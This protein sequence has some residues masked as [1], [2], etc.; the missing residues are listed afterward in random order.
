MTHQ[1]NKITIARNKTREI[2]IGSVTIGNGHPIAIQS[3]TNTDTRNVA[4]TVAQ[5]EAL[6]AEGCEIVRVA[7]PDKEA[8]EAIKEIKKKCS[9][10]PLI[11]DVHYDYRLGIM[12]VKNGADKLR[13]NPGNIGAR[14]NV[15]KLVEIAKERRVPIRVGVNSGSLEKDI[16]GKFGGV[17]TEGL[18]ESALRH[19]A[20]L[21]SL[22]F[23]DIVVAIKGSNV[24]VT[25]AAYEL[26]AEKTD[27]PLH[28]G[29]TESGT[30]YSG[31]I[32]SAVGIGA[33]L[34]R[35][36]G[37]TIRVSLTGNPVEEV[38][39]AKEILKALELR[40]FGAEYIS[41]PTCGRTEID[42][43]GIVKEVEERCKGIKEN[44]K[45]AV[46]GCVVN[47]PGEAK[48]ADFGIAGGKGCG[49]VFKKGEIVKRV[50]EAEL[51]DTLMDVI[52]NG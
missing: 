48:E 41:C 50:G 14:E 29:I 25:L 26:L 28:V 37:D 52:N 39:C 2:N 24:P 30:V 47:G 42:L 7:V 13:I 19:V 3:M 21:E 8:A 43:I 45:I 35:G 1:S 34:S 38:K 51:V 20:V 16:L 23:F 4:A 46:M 44:I 22:D 33:I 32:K 10:V 18:V 31:S 15:G 9:A 49:I 12:A 6:V 17:T 27:Y 11:A 36:I 5:I 40:S